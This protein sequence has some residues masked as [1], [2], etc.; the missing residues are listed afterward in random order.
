M[1]AVLIKALIE[2]IFIIYMFLL[3]DILIKEGEFLEYQ[4]GKNQ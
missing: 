2:L 4:N 1:Y 3:H